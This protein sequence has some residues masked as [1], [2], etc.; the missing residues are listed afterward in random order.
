[1]HTLRTIV[2]GLVFAEGPRWHDGALYFSDMHG[3][4]VHR[5]EPD[6]ALTTVATIDHAT[7]GLG[8][9]PDGR[10]LVVAMEAR[11]VM[12]QEPDGRMVEHADLSGVATFHC[13]DMIVAADG[14]AFVGNFGFPLFPLGEPCTAAVAC[15]RADGTVSVGADGLWFPNGLAITPDGQTLII[16]ESA[17]FCL[18]AFTIGADGKLTDRRLWAALE[19]GASPDGICLDAQG[20]AWV[21]IPH[22]S[23][24]VRVLEGAAITDSISVEGYA[25]ACMIGGKTGHTLFMAVSGEI[26]PELCLTKPS[27]AILA[28]EIPIPAFR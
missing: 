5:V 20:A 11:K 15:V 4:C 13:N 12:R 3:K 6:G 21:A 8:W 17:G 19:P 24:F 7:S 10:L 18:T 2:E 26:E 22:Q 23:K 16:A 14:T 9:L 27:G 1:M 25:L 28:T